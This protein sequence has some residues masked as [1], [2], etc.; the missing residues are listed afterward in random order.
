MILL[1]TILSF[2]RDS[3]TLTLPLNQYV[4]GDKIDKVII[5][6]GQNHR[7]IELEKE[8]MIHFTPR[9]K[10]D[11]LLYGDIKGDEMMYLG[12]GMMDGPPLLSGKRELVPDKKEVRGEL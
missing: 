11:G 3:K 6:L 9:Y 2:N 8:V 12:D 4:E 10:K 1:S 7:P 5:R